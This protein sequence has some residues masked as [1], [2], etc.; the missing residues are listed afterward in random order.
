MKCRAL[1]QML[2]GSSVAVLVQQ[3]WCNQARPGRHAWQKRA[4]GVWPWREKLRMGKSLTGVGQGT[5]TS[6]RAR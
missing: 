4:H 2:H 6:G 3:R 5:R 1:G